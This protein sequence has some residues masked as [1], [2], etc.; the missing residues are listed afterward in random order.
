MSRTSSG[1]DTAAVEALFARAEA[2]VSGGRVPS[3][4]LAIARGDEVVTT[5][6]GAP[7][8][9]RFVM[10]S[11]SKSLVAGAMWVLFGEG[12]LSPS[13]RVAEVIPE[14]GTNGKDVVTV[15]H[16]LTHT[17]GFPAAPLRPEEGAT[18]EGRLARFAEWRLDW[19]PGTRT[20]YHP[21]SAHWV[22]AELIERAGGVDYRDFVDK[23]VVAPLGVT[24]LRLGVPEAEQDDIVP[25]A[26]VGDRDAAPPAG[27]EDSALVAETGA[28]LLLRYNDP[29]VRAIGVPGAGG[30]GT[31][32]DMA[33]YFQAM[34]H[35]P[36]G[37]WDDSVL[38]DAT[39]VIRNTLPD[40]FTNIPANRSLGLMIAGD[41][42]NAF[43][44]EFG[45]GVGPRAFL[46][47]GAGGQVAWAD[48]DTGLSFCFL[49]SGID[50]D[51]V[52]SFLRSSKLSTMA[53]A[54]VQ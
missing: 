46:S 36:G 53:A 7:D 50:A 1:F 11:L 18:S 51:V 43:M 8:N 22:L 35:N 10:F 19:E 15:E 12:A 48:P 31:A 40:P 54:C 16:L 4:Q 52:K 33:R 14:F 6:F 29:A 28:Q 42:G 27:M 13:T 30:V 45:E 26:V 37:I 21:T 34:L 47:S 44:R 17:G 23:R 32:R 3:C 24:T 5:T 41:D 38:R 49:T 2:E 39:S 9:A 25:L 20:S